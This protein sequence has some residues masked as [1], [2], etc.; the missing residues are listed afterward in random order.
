ME[1][2]PP[3][4]ALEA[5]EERLAPVLA[6]GDYKSPVFVHNSYKS[7]GVY[8]EQ[9]ARFYRH[10]PKDRLLVES[11][12]ELSKRPDAVLRRV[13]EFVGVD[14]SFAVPNRTKRNVGE[15]KEHVEPRVRAYLDEFFRPH[16]Q[17]LYEL[18]GKNFGW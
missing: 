5:E 7:R 10:F 3:L 17:A 13:F 16:N 1:S 4:A 6:R 2:L 14:P 12:E 18:V 15:N 11:T 9:L 8:H